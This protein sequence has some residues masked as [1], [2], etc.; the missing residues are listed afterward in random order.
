MKEGLELIRARQQRMA[1]LLLGLIPFVL[2]AGY[3]TRIVFIL[4]AIAYGV[5][6]LAYSLRLAFTEC[7]RCENFYHWNWWSNPWTRRCLH[8]GLRLDG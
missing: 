3:F 1:Y 8:C 5:L 7:P 2:V 6:L 4:A